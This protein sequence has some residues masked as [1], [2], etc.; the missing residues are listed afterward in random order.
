MAFAVDK[1][2]TVIERA[3]GTIRALSVAVV[4]DEESIDTATATELESLVAAAVGFDQERGDTL[5]L[6]VI[7]FDESFDPPAE[8]AA[9]DE[10]AAEEGGL[11]AL[12]PLIRMGV[13]GL[14]AFL[15]TVFTALFALRGRRGP[16]VVSLRPAD[17]EGDNPNL[18]AIGA[19]AVAA[20]GSGARDSEPT[21]LIALIESQPDDVAGMLRSWMADDRAGET[22]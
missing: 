11:A 21:D 7:P 15:A 12:L 16:Q 2:I 22:V 17:L 14:V 6:T 4:L 3:P 5:A 1:T 20:L 13:I 10:E 8:L 19:A 18:E 9:T